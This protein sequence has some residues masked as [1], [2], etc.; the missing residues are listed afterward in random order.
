MKMIFILPITNL[1]ASSTFLKNEK[2]GSEARSGWSVVVTFTIIL[3]GWLTIL[4]GSAE[5]V[6]TAQFH[7]GRIEGIVVS[8]DK[9]MPF[10]HLTV[11]LRHKP[12]DKDRTGWA[13][14]RKA[15]TDERG[16]FVFDQVN[17]GRYQLSVG[18]EGY[19]TRAY[20]DRN[21]GDPS[22]YLEVDEGAVIS[23]IRIN[24]QPG[25]KISGT[26]LNQRGE[27]LSGFDVKLFHLRA[28]GEPFL[29]AE[30]ETDRS[31]HYYLDKILP[32]RY[33]LRAERIKRD[34]AST[35]MEVGYH[36]VAASLDS[37]APIEVNPGDVLTN[38]DVTVNHTM[39]SAS[40]T[41]IVINAQTGKPL[42]QVL[43]VAE[44]VWE[45]SPRN[46][47]KTLTAAD[48]A[49][50]LE[51]MLPGLYFIKADGREVENGYKLGA[52]KL[53]VTGEHIIGFELT[54]APLIVA[55]AQYIGQ[56]RPPAPGDF[57]VSLQSDCRNCE[58][59]VSI[60]YRGQWT[61]EFRGVEAAPVRIGAGFA[62]PR[63]KLARVLLNDED[64]TDKWIN[65]RPGE[66]L[67]GVRILITDQ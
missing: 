3:A 11:W 26:V 23:G 39:K 46:P 38:V 27:P 24:V 40:I 50:R 42:P 60:P 66:K 4:T 48:G 55:T 9:G 19:I 59:G 53:L 13:P 67:T 30:A 33:V 21:Q 44:E 25:G 6:S 45:R 62:S 29:A 58:T 36:R 1:T 49:Y 8:A 5:P 34:K 18:P 12:E 41:G 20:P 56:D 2:K 15:Q 14:F 61:F 7:P 32:N 35:W 22:Q 17:P 52:K 16:R 28:A 57:S 51:G 37:A 31:G 47:P 63:Y 64:I 65:L 10:A 43:V 54:P